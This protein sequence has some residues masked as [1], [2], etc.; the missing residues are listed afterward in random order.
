M[1]N[2][3]REFVVCRF[4]AFQAVFVSHEVL[5]STFVTRWSSESRLEVQP[6]LTTVGGEYHD[7]VTAAIS[8][9][10]PGDFYDDR[11]GYATREHRKRLSSTYLSVSDTRGWHQ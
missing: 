8:F 9:K 10:T 4:Q 6:G 3:V 5:N 1:L 2:A 7:E 11:F